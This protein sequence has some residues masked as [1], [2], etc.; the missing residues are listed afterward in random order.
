M[1]KKDKNNPLYLIMNDR[2]FYNI[3]ILIHYP[4]FLI[5]KFQDH[6]AGA[7]YFIKIDLKLGFYFI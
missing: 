3:I 2:G 7:K 4:I 5:N 6:L 1:E